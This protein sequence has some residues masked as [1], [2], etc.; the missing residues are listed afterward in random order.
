MTT[1][2]A[3]CPT[4]GDVELTPPQVR[5]V[6]CTVS[7]WSFYAFGCP[8][9]SDEVRKHASDDVVRLLTTGGVPAEH[10]S[11]PAEALEEHSGST[12]SWDD[13]L[14]FTLALETTDVVAAAA[15]SV[16]RPRHVG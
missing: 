8:G 1:I 10:W 11:V 14:D 12:I 9:C 13:V 2:K 4:C 6:V 5:L 7:A 16:L 15:A 3:S